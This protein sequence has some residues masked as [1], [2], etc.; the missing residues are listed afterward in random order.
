LS[1]NKTLLIWDSPS[2]DIPEH[3]T[4]AFWQSY[5]AESKKNEISIPRLVEKDADFFK[6][7]YL[8]F[9]YDLGEAQ[10]KEKK[11]VEQL[12]V[13]PRF[14]YWWMTL[15]SEKCNYSKS[16][17][18]NN[19]IKMMAFDEW[20]NKREYQH[21]LLV[22]SN[23]QLSEAILLM[24]KD[25]N[26]GFKWKKIK[27]SRSNKYSAKYFY[28]QFPYFLQSLMW[29]VRYLATY[30]PLKGV[31]VKEWE[32]SKAETMFV[33]YFSNFIPGSLNNNLFKSYFWG[34]LTNLLNKHKISSN[35]LHIYTKNDSSLN[36]KDVINIVNRLNKSY[37]GEQT[38]V[39][40]HSFLSF[41]LVL[42]VLKDWILLL[43]MN[44]KIGMSLQEESGVYWPLLK[45][46]FLSSVIGS[47]AISNLFSLYLFDKAMSMLKHQ[48]KGFYLKE[49]QS[50]EFGFIY[51]WRTYG[52]ADKLIG[53]PH[54]TVIFW[55][56]RYFFD[57][58]SYLRESICALPLPDYVGVNGG[59]SK[60]MYIE[61]GY[62][63]NYLIE[64][65]ALR[66]MDLRKIKSNLKAN[67][68]GKIVL[69]VLGDYLQENTTQMMDLLQSAS[70]LIQKE[71][72]YLIKP[73]PSCAVLAEDYPNLKISVTDSPIHMLV[74]CFTIALTS[75]AT[76]AVLDVRYTGKPIMSILNPLSLN[77]SPLKD[78]ES[79]LFIST[80]KDLANI[81]NNI[82]S[83]DSNINSISKDFFYLDS[84]LSK[85]KE[86]LV[87]DKLVAR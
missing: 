64:L 11:V 18:V 32:C 3:Y 19:I 60:R 23:K 69:L 37:K 71:V 70:N 22:S 62:P 24:A 42:S 78:D 13:R 15:V 87:Y 1:K 4:V 29:I 17:Q 9:I 86:L 21:I 27:Q 33:S 25:L 77:L 84:K 47:E 85:W 41:R 48:K 8:S 28:H 52:H 45:E 66:Y 44:K 49:N 65:E 39:L 35:W 57:K 12:E 81:L 30:W 26:I 50:W 56:M 54:T 76:S 55:D 7:K 59:A 43:F 58:R 6:S 72:E 16:P 14:S 82:D 67:D 53:I 74:D 10:V 80:S 51:A 2:Q 40:I 38:H 46:D 75:N 63:K 61:G 5:K 20:F 79:I 73:H 36:R 68:R 31:G 83:I 34:D